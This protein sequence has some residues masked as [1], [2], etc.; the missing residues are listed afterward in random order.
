MSDR[1]AS[2]GSLVRIGTRGSSLALAQAHWVKALLEKH[3]PGIR[4]VIAAIITSGDRLHGSLARFGGKGLFVKEIE[5]A[6][7]HGRVDLAVHSMKDMPVAVADGLVISAVPTR[8]DPRDVMVGAP[9][10]GEGIH[11]LPAGASVGTTSLRRRAQLLAAR[12]DLRVVEIRGNVDTRLRKRAEGACDAVLLAAAGLVRL[13]IGIEVGTPLDPELFV[14]AVGQ[15]ALAL[16]TRASDD[17][18]R[19][20]LAT[21]NDEMASSTVAAE[22][23]F[24]KGLGGDCTTPIAAHARRDAD[25][26]RLT[27]LVATPDG[28][29]VL[30]DT[31]TGTARAPEAVGMSLASC[32]RGRGADGILAQVG[33]FGAKR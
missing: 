13:A 31:A 18:L 11:G 19:E 16:E 15:G 14:P 1:A 26:L 21:V 24:L 10:G 17:E 27:G 8:A 32:L 3:W 23:A 28:C 6:L 29:R 5:D 9:I 2:S 30:K 7:Y 20:M 12:P 4:V 25:V 22:R 33:R